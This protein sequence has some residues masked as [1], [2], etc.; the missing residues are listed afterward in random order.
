MHIMHPTQ[1]ILVVMLTC[2]LLVYA[3][4]PLFLTENVTPVDDIYNFTYP[5]DCG[6]TFTD[7]DTGANETVHEVPLY[8][9]TYVQVTYVSHT[10]FD[11]Y[12]SLVTIIS[13][14]HPL[15]LYQQPNLDRTDTT[16]HAV[17]GT[18][19]QRFL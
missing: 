19:Q 14:P 8:I 18:T 15:F 12:C 1:L 16:V 5:L 9:H 7:N 2:C 17:V 6:Q 13:L 4:V 3:L 10:C 11:L